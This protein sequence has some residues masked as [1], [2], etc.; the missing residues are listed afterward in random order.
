MKFLLT[1]FF[2]MISFWG[3]AQPIQPDTNLLDKDPVFRK[4]L[5]RR[6][7]YPIMNALNGGR[8]KLVYAQFNIDE[9]GH[10][11]DVKVV[12][13]SYAPHG[14]RNP[15]AN[16][17]EIVEKTLN[18]LPPLN[19]RYLGRY[20]LPVIFAMNGTDSKQI[21]TNNYNSAI[22]DHILLRSVTV[23]G[24]SYRGNNGTSEPGKEIY[25]TSRQ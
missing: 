20:V 16:F 14:I 2:V 24:Y 17:D 1:T 10:V 13:P 22:I 6:L 8:T 23:L 7:S 21:I 9:K 3:F 4:V 15:D 11:Q 18:R 25:N 12:H 5:K 19:P